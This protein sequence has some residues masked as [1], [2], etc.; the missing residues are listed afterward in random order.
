MFGNN[1]VPNPLERDG[2]IC[3]K[4][5]TKIPMRCLD[6]GPYE[7]SDNYICFACY[8]EF[9]DGA[10]LLNEKDSNSQE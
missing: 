1:L 3:D 10:G 8:E 6:G 4:C 9:M 2:Y 5:E 7:V